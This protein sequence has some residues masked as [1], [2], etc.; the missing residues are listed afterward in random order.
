[1][2]NLIFIFFLTLLSVFNLKKIEKTPLEVIICVTKNK[3]IIQISKELYL[4][5]ISKNYLDSISYLIQNLEKIKNIINSCSEPS[6]INLQN[7]NNKEKINM[8]NKEFIEIMNTGKKVK[9]G[10]K[11]HLK[12]IELSNEAMKITSEINSNYKTPIEIRKLMSK[13]IDQELDEN[14]GLFPP[15]YTDCGKNIHIGKGVFINSGCK[16]QDQGGIYIGDNSLI[17]H[18]TVI[19]TLNHDINP[20][21]RGDTIPKTVRIGKN[22]WI[23]SGV[24]I[25]PGINIGDNAVIGAGSIVTKDVPKDMI[26]VG[27]PAKVI[28]SI[29]D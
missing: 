15:F 7:Y 10:S 6:E 20:K 8:S 5:I 12:M 24:I 19:A 28:K 26:A 16:F 17:G 1:M 11:V 9:A 29:Y 2:R 21:F 4:K 22:V 14:F 23:G 25:L 18:N 27:N 13:L 3:D